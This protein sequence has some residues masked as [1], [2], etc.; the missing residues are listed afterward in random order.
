MRIVMLNPEPKRLWDRWIKRPELE[1]ESIWQPDIEIT[2]RRVWEGWAL[3]AGGVGPAAGTLLLLPVA[4][5]ASRLFWRPAT[6][7]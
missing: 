1:W 6:E 7:M 2:V 4:N 5:A 3:A